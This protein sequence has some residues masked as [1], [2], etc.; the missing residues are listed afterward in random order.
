MGAVQEHPDHVRPHTLPDFTQEDLSVFDPKTPREQ[1]SALASTLETPLMPPSSSPGQQRSS[2]NIAPIP[3]VIVPS[4][5]TRPAQPAQPENPTPFTLP[6]PP[7]STVETQPAASRQLDDWA[8]DK[9]FE[10]SLQASQR[11]PQQKKPAE[12]LDV[13]SGIAVGKTAEPSDNITPPAEKPVIPTPQPLPPPE[14]PR[15]IS[16]AGYL[17]VIGHTRAVR[18]TLRQGDDT[19]K[20]ALARSE[21]LDQLCQRVAADA[22]AVQESLMRID[23]ALYEEV[24]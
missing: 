20:E 22:N 7:A 15:F 9:G 18:K 13:L 23:A 6:P 14:K 5:P 2:A 11:T 3:V 24:P 12:T 8:S 17:D 16:S 4:E 21:Q 1:Q 19:I 10:K